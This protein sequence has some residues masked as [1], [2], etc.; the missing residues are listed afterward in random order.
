MAA[1]MYWDLVPPNADAF[2]PRNGLIFATGPV[3]GF[4][5]LSGSRWQVCA[6]SPSTDPQYF[7]YSNLG[8][9]WGSHLKLAGYDGLIVEGAADKPVYIAIRDGAVE[10]RD[11]A[12]LWQKTARDVIET[13]KEETGRSMR[14]VASGPAGDN[15]VA[16]AGMTADGDACGSSGMGAVMGSK[17]L[18]AIAVHGSGKV[19]AARPE[20]LRGL[21]DDVRKLRK[22]KPGQLEKLM[23]TGS[24]L[25]REAC[26]GCIGACTGRLVYTAEDGTKGKSMCQSSVFYMRPAWKYHGKQTEVPFF[27]N[28]I[29][30]AYGLDTMVV[31]SVLVLLQRCAKAGILT[32]DNAGLPFSK[33]GSL[34]FIETLVRKIAFREGIGDILA[35][36][37]TK[38]AEMIG[39]GAP[40]LI[41]DYL[42]IADHP[43]AYCPRMYISTGLLYAT[44]HRQPIQQLHA[45]SR[46]QLQW[47]SRQMGNQGSHVTSDLVRRINRSFWGGEESCD[48]S[49]YAGKA[50]AAKHIQDR[51]YAQECLILCDFAWPVTD[52]AVPENGDHFGDPTLESKI[53]SA[54]TGRQTNEAG[55]NEIGERI[56]NL[57]RAILS[58]EGHAGRDA[59]RIAEMFYTVPLK[60]AFLN[61]ECLATGKDGE[62]I[63]RKGAVV[64]REQFEAMKTE[65]YSLRG[66]DAATGL[67]SRA[68]LHQLDLADIARD[69][70]PKCLSE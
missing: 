9:H 66:W 26:F 35:C 39:N 69:L 2:D 55:L 38:A 51:L 34:E 47:V 13:I 64:D 63:S 20:D 48:Y 15:L 18:K 19:A 58:R 57:Q 49:T 1:K 22:L 8:G 45:V 46:L 61:P 65:Y 42:A 21:V 14:V 41:A 36:G 50:L 3:A 54:V 37:T 33:I 25:K 10:I 16:F 70:D 11:A 28:R 68:K 30:D 60:D 4:G 23:P 62:A 56:F 59:D 52:V 40:E 24:R 12:H 27:A 29:C 31:D 17:K 6:K 7:S 43:P 67:Q 44:E 32:E 5:G 53:Y